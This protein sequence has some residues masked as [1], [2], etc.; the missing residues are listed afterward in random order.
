M[1]EERFKKLLGEYAF[2]VTVLQ[3]QLETLQSELAELKK[4]KPDEN[5]SKRS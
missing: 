1:L 3:H 2:Q 5:K 4:E